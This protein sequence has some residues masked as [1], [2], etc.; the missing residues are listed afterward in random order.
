MKNTDNTQ[1]ENDINNNCNGT[2]HHKIIKDMNSCII[3]WKYLLAIL[4][5][6]LVESSSTLAKS[7]DAAIPLTETSMTLT[8][9]VDLLS[10]TTK[11]ASSQ[12][13]TTT[14]SILAAEYS[15]T[16][17][18]KDLVKT[19]YGLTSSTP[20]VAQ[21]SNPISLPSTVS[22]KQTSSAPDDLLKGFS[23]PTLIP[24]LSPF[25][26]DQLAKY[27]PPTPS[28]K[29]LTSTM[30]TQSEDQLYIAAYQQNRRRP[31]FSLAT[32]NITVQLGNHAYLSCNI[33]R[34]LNKPISWLRIRDG[35]ILS[36]DQATFISDQRFQSVFQGQSEN[37]WSL[38]IKYVQKSDEG[39]YECQ[40]P[41]EPKMSAKIHLGV[42]VPHTELIGDRNRFVKAGSRVALH[43]IVR[44]TLEP[45]A[46]IIWFRGKTQITNDNEMGW[47]TEIDRTIFGNADSSSNTI[48]SLIIPCVRKLDSDTY[49]CEPSNSASVS[50]DLHVLNGEYSASAIMSV[51]G[52]HRLS[53]SVFTCHLSF[54]LLLQAMG[55]T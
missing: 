41:T 18:T 4:F 14:Q 48:G 51:A 24:P 40:V 39:W 6:V 38:Q 31:N 10:T 34:V 17:I 2:N 8:P 54:L 50:V 33:Q 19:V 27:P 37:T 22:S 30:S 11:T 26:I 15:L 20:P 53:K 12:N 45:P 32:K 25:A 47:Y 42:V 44:D 1:V 5:F 55:K 46:Y 23:M 52:S 29:P 16:P 35:H 28:I 3:T 49:T 13:P 36:V 9:V 43:C 21:Q 7:Q